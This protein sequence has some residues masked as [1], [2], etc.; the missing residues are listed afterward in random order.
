MLACLLAMFVFCNLLNIMTHWFGE[1]G[2]W[3]VSLI[4][5]KIGIVVKNIFAVEVKPL[6]LDL[7]MDFV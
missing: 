4:L 1:V 5:L 3:T 7:Q 2:H 6:C